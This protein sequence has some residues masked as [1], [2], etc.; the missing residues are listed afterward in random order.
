MAMTEEEKKIRK[1]F[2]K[3]KKNMQALSVWRDEFRPTVEAYAKLRFQYDVLFEKWQSDGCNV[4][5]EYTNKS[6]ASNNRKTAEYQV[7]EV[8]RK[9]ILT[10][11]NT[12]G[13]TP[14]GLKKI[15]QQELNKKKKS[16]MSD[17]IRS[18]E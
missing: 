2:N 7:L 17:K 10:Y 9:D 14:I 4:V 5:E 3:T 15:R 13:L 1:I 12:L 11:E 6:G 8:L 18:L 16:S